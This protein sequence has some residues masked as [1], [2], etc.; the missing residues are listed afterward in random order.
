[1]KFYLYILLPLL[2]IC[3]ACTANHSTSTL[4]SDAEQ[5]AAVGEYDKAIKMCNKLT[6]TADSATL[7]SADYCRVAMVYITASN[8]DVNTDVNMS[9]A[10]RCFDNAYRL[11]PDTLSAFVENLPVDALASAHMALQLLRN[12]SVDM[13]HIMEHEEPDSLPFNDTITA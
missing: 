2:S 13:S 9:N 1:M 10:V 8:A 11:D 5:A 3:F 7:T 12:R 6:D 4:V